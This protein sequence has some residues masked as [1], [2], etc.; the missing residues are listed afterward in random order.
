M[1]IGSA[2]DGTV[3][4]NP[5]SALVFERI[6]EPY[7]NIP[8]ILRSTNTARLKSRFAFF[9]RGSHSSIFKAKK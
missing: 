3:E 7:L 5:V 4:G 1:P 2:T 8:S 6:N 9:E